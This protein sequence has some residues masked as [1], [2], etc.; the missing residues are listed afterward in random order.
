MR[1]KL[2]AVLATAATLLT[3]A[4]DFYYNDIPSPDDALHLVP[5]FDA[6]IKQPAVYPYARADVP[7]NT[8]PGTVPITGSEGDWSAEFGSGNTTTADK[9]VNPLAGRDAP[10][11]GDTLYQTFCAVC[12]GLAGAGD[13]PVGP[14]VAAPSLL[15]D[16]AK[17]YSDGYLYSIIRY[18]RGVM[19]R[20]GDK[21][22]GIKRWEIVN[23]VRQLQNPPAPAGTGFQQTTPGATAQ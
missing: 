19:P 9:L 12:H 3:G 7:R 10:A 20:Y 14:Q 5:W 17:A 11:R 22:R 21:V 1:R 4:C 16:K 13:G 2:T 23:Y 18:G 15:T 6:M 8:V